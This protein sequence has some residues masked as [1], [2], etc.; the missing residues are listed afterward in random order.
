MV[1][2]MVFIG[3]YLFGGNGLQYLHRLQNENHKLEHEIIVLQTQVK[4]IESQ[5]AAWQADDFYKEKIAREKLQMAKK[6]DQIYFI[7]K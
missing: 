5:I 1:E 3:V 7:E 2:V 4:E 6:D